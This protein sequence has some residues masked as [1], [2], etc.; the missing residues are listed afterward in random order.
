M[1]QVPGSGEPAQASLLAVL[2]SGVDFECRTTAHPDLITPDQLLD[3]GCLL[4]GLGVRHYAVQIFRTQG[5]T[6]ETLNAHGQSLGD[7][8]GAAVSSALAAL[9]PSFTL[10]RA[11]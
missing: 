6:D 11:V 3:L 8:P 9:F 7:W 10:R 1:T 2:K 5:C 4:A